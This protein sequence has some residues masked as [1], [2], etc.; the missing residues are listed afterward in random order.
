VALQL[1]HGA[2]EGRPRLVDPRADRHVAAVEVAELVREDTAQ[3][4]DRQRLQQR[5]PEAHHA[6][7]AQAHEAAALV[8]PGV[9]V[10]DQVDLGRLVLAGPDGEIADLGERGRAACP[11]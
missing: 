9:G 10:G 7:A 3:L 8:D 4:R 2:H 6:P 5:Q 1:D 11:A